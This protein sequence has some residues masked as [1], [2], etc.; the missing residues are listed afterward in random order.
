MAIERLCG[1]IA[2]SAAAFSFILTP[3]RGSQI[4]RCKREG[5]LMEQIAF[6]VVTSAAFG[7]VAAA[8]LGMLR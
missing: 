5:R 3:E 4:Q 7:L 8:I 2:I 6:M 1:G